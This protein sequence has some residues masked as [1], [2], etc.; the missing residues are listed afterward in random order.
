MEVDKKRFAISMLA[1]SLMGLWHIWNF[2]ENLNTELKNAY[3]ALTMLH[4]VMQILIVYAVSRRDADLFEPIMLILL[5][6]YCIFVY[7]PIIDIINNDYTTFGVNPMSACPKSCAI[8]AL[9]SIIFT[10]AYYSKFRIRDIEKLNERPSELNNSYKQIIRN[11]YVIWLIAFGL[12]VLNQLISGVSL[13]YIFSMSLSGTV[14]DTVDTGIAALS[15]FTYAMIAPWMYILIFGHR[16][17]MKVLITFSMICICIIRGKRI[18]LLSMTVAPILYFYLSRKK[19]PKTVMVLLAVIVALFAASLMQFARH[20]VRFGTTNEFSWES[21]SS[22]MMTNVFDADFTTYKQFYAIVAAYPSSYPYT[23]GRAIIVQTLLTMIP[24]VIWP[25]KPEVVIL[26]V[27]KNAVNQQAMNSGMAAPNIGEY[28]FEF[29]VL[30]CVV[31][32][33]IV[34]KIFRHWKKYIVSDEVE[35]WIMYSC[36]YGIIFQLIIRTSTASIVY[37]YIFT[38]LPLYL[39]RKLS[40]GK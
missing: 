17:L 36:L 32:M 22:V 27:I 15:F 35:R 29:G 9:S 30:G 39:I 37:Q 16:R 26:E 14:S 18:I 4:F 40:I 38:I 1:M 24:R 20:G 33:F 28:Y 5:L 31:L 23:M 11:S 10:L 8:V 21:F 25:R 2:P 6:Y 13:S 7:R 19:R 12:S 34:G 3:L